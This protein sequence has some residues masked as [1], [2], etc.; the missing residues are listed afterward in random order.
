M[1][2]PIPNFT[3]TVQQTVTDN[4][5]DNNK[6]TFALQKN[7][8]LRE[9]IFTPLT[10]AQPF[11]KNLCTEIHENPTNLLVADTMSRTEGSGLEARCS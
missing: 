9:R 7:V 10:F 1:W 8:I 11:I 5:I 6:L 2:R 3:Q 4:N